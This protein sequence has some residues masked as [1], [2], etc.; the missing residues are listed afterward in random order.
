VL[1]GTFET[2]SLP[3]VLGLLASARK[4]GAL[5]LESGPVSGVVHVED[6]HCRAV[7]TAQQRGPVDHSPDL[8]ERLVEV[9]FG[10]V[11][12]ERGTFR[13][14]ADEPAPWRC[15]EPVELSDALLEVERLLKQWREVVRVI[16]S[17]DCRPRLL[18]ALVVEELVLDR[19][20]WTLLVALDG[21]RTVRAVVERV[22]RPVLEVCH[23]LLELVDAGAVGI[24]DPDVPRVEPT[25]APAVE[26]APEPAPFPVAEPPPA[27]PVERAPEPAPFP[28]AEPPPAPA[29]ERA[30]EPA[31]FPVAE[32]PPAP[33]VERAPEPPPVPPPASL[34][35]EERPAFQPPPES[36]PPEAVLAE[37]EAEAEER[38]P[39]P[40][41][42]EPERPAA[43]APADRGTFLRMFSGLREN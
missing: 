37:A 38:E 34:P 12:L 7:E 27:P 31:P 20:L 16:P 32:P 26:R 21:R 6:G 24:L 5:S 10:V 8:L 25:P 23:S 35:M 1:Q 15:P 18:D 22:G 17:L 39:D 14:A 2:L 9:C 30:P 36:V 13:F 29:V 41:A 28:V 4:T 3:E 43:P 42:A 19:A 11:R 33:P 40:P